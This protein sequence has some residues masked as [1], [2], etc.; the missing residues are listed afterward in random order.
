MID[1]DVGTG[2]SGDQEIGRKKSELN[3]ENYF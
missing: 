1:S 3:D 2:L